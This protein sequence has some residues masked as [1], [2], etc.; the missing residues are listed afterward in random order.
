MSDPAPSSP[1]GENVPAWASELAASY[2]SGAASVFLLHGNVHDLVPVDG[3]DG[4]VSL[5]HYLATQLFGQ[6]DIVLSYDR[7][8]G[9]RFVAP[10][11]SERRST[12]QE[13]FHK[14]LTAIDLV[15]GTSFAK[16]RPKDPTLVFELMDRYILHKLLDATEDG[17]RKSLAIVIRYLETITPAIEG[18]MLGGELGTNLIKVLNWANDPGIRR[19]D[20]TLCLVTESLGDVNRRLV[21]NPF[22]S[23]VE[24][25]L[26][27]EPTRR[28]YAQ[29]IVRDK[30]IARSVAREANGL[31]LVGVSQ[32][33]SHAAQRASGLE[34]ERLR[35]TKKS[36]IEKQCFGLI[37]FITPRYGLDTV[38]APKPVKERLEQGR[39][40]LP[41]RPLR[42][43]SDGLSSLRC[44]RNGEDVHRDV[45][46]REPRRARDRI[47]ELAEQVGRKLGGES[48]KGALRHQS[49]RSRRRRHR[50]S[51]RSTRSPRSLGR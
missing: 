20:V 47:Q 14:T 48:S 38:I 50:R 40:A 25:P 24:I 6:R 27:D 26:P 12:M 33:V 23:K 1:L 29:T 46:C 18:S 42:S 28:R 9:I 10:D 30:S 4:F 41:E 5:E 19:A 37:E 35:R 45:F 51:R 43:A 34:L 36:L 3:G 8:S 17:N 16:S 31:T 32:A 44:H 7:G 15:N 13:D 11:D 49:A 39:P 2:V 22:I 21:E